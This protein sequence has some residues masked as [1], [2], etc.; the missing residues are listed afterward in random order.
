MEQFWFYV[1]LF[2]FILFVSVTFLLHK[3]RKR[4]NKNLPPSPLAFPIIGHLHILKE[5]LHR[6]LHHLSDQY[7]PILYLHFGSRPVLLITSPSAVEECFTKNDII[8]ANRPQLLVGKH[9]YNYTSL[10]ASSYGSHW[11][12]LRRLSTI[13]LF[14]ST[15]LNI[16]SDLRPEEVRLLIKDLY[17]VLCED[18]VK[19]ELKSRFSD[20]S[21]NVIMR[22]ISGKQYCKDE[23]GLKE[24]KQFQQIT[25][26][27]FEV[28]GIPNL[29]DFFP[30]LSFVDWNGLEKRMK[31]LHRKADVLLQRLI[32]EHRNSHNYTSLAEEGE[33]KTMMDV[34][35]SLQ[36][37][38]PDYYTDEIIK[39]FLLGLLIAGTDTSATTLEWAMSLLLNHP[40][41]LR[42]VKAEVDDVLH[43]GERVHHDHDHDS[44][45]HLLLIDEQQ[46]LAKMKYLQ[47]VINETLRL[48]PP[49][50]LLVP[51]E[52]SKDC[53]VGGYDV[54]G[55]T[56]LIVNIWSIHRDPKLWDDPTSFKP[57]RFIN[58]EACRPPLLLPFGMGRRGCP[59]AGL[60]NRVV[61]VALATLIQCFEWKRLGEKEVDLTEGPGLTAPKAKPLEA[62]CKACPTMI[63]VL[64]KL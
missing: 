43:G 3:Q 1:V 50:P 59:A 24:A 20:L 55:G 38:E 4:N 35:L 56:I 48:F 6:S 64:S 32:N 30:S 5:P 14:S 51:H 11:R 42:K 31:A 52:S 19:V 47:C 36:H 40:E 41:V 34:L 10:G 60:A 15:R 9:M 37:R 53:T 57:E 61:G 33:M 13:E 44:S 26:E 12:N 2:S 23:V 62:M 46:H 54:L 39:S 25:S 28:S 45:T 58:E 21:F 7:G 27:I 18:F 29:G 17:R 63:N 8:F 22:M 49:A 16:F